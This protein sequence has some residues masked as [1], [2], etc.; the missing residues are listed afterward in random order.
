MCKDTKLI[1]NDKF[2][3]PYFIFYF[4][5]NKNTY[6]LPNTPTPIPFFKRSETFHPFL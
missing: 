6:S 5:L 1:D 4:Y 2:L 3:S